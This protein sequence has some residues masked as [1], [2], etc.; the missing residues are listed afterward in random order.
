MNTIT[1]SNEYLTVEISPM[2][3]ELQSIRKGGKEYLWNGD[4]AVWSG[5][6]PLLFPICGAL[7]DDK[8]IFEGKKYTLPRHGFARYS[9]FEAELKESDK[10]VFLLRSSAETLKSY[11]FE[12]ELRV[13]YTLDKSKI[14]IEYAVKNLSSGDMYFSIG[15]HE[16]YACPEGIEEYSVIFDKAENLISNRLDGGLIAG[17]TIDL[18][19]DTCELPLKCEYFEE[20]S[21][22]FLNLNSRRVVLKN[23]NTGAEIEVQFEGADYFLIWQKPGANYICLEPWCG[24]AD[25]TDSDFDITNKRGIIKL[26]SNDIFIKKHSITF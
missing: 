11:P 6:A 24:I 18:G 22:N 1:I 4:P 10:A 8:F 19:T 20:D 16:A 5:R 25:F 9:Q 7:K 3:A 17:K 23:R 15:S 21:L 14:N 13:S 26:P 2:G 12:F